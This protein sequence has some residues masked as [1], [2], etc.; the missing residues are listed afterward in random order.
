MKFK[1]ISKN[2]KNLIFTRRC[3]ICGQV[4][5]IRRELCRECEE[6]PYRIEGEICEKCGVPKKDCI[7]KGA[8]FYM[9]VCAPFFYDGGPKRGFYLMKFR[10]DLAITEQLGKEM[11]QCVRERYAG[12]D[13]D[14]VTFTPSHKKDIRSRGYN[15]AKRLAEI[16]SRE[17]NLSCYDLISKDYQTATQHSLP[18]YL[19]TGNLAGALSYNAQADCNIENMRILLCDDLKT[20][21]TTLNESSKILLFNG[22]AEIRCV[23]ACIKLNK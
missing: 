12:Y 5:D 8:P 11:A 1:D 9:S 23:T 21:G 3:I 6:S 16:I 13:F 20:T 17:L 18:G 14:C 4:C 19:R 15:Q 2:L 22:A 10:N 7:C